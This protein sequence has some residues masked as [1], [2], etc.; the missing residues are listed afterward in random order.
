MQPYGLILAIIWKNRSHHNSHLFTIQEQ[1]IFTCV[2]RSQNN[3]RLFGGLVDTDYK[4]A[5]ESYLG[6]RKY[7]ASWSGWLHK[8]IHRYKLS[9]ILSI[10]AHKITNLGEGKGMEP[11]YYSLVLTLDYLI[12]EETVK[13]NKKLFITITSRLNLSLPPK[14]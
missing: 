11:E 4:G 5:Q 1:V 10:C 7:S 14:K 8:C 2:D 6:Y 12:T 9:C 3:S 13:Y